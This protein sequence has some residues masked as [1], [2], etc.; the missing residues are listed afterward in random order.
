VDSSESAG[1][2]ALLLLG[3]AAAGRTLGAGQDAA[4]GEDQDMAVGELLLELT[5]EALLHTV[6]TGQGRDGDKD[7][8]SLL[9]VANLDLIKI[10][11]QHASSRTNALDRFPSCSSEVNMYFGGAIGSPQLA[12]EKGV[13]FLADHRIE[14][15]WEQDLER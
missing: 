13:H 14:Q 6:E 7:D 3:V 5:G 2:G 15:L 10:Q 1:T 11:S 8:N 12:F 9:A 4:R